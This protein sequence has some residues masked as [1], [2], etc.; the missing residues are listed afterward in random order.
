MTQNEVREPLTYSGFSIYAGEKP[1]SKETWTAG[2]IDQGG[3]QVGIRYGV[4]SG[5]AGFPK[6]TPDLAPEVRRIGQ[7]LSAYD[8]LGLGIIDFLSDEQPADLRRVVAATPDAG[9]PS[10]ELIK[11]AM[12]AVGALLKVDLISFDNELRL[13]LTAL[14]EQIIEHAR[15][16]FDEESDRESLFAE[17]RRVIESDDEV[18]SYD[19]YLAELAAD[20]ITVLP[21]E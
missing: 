6:K 19:D 8:A 9:K 17:A 12:I 3:D 21:G 11:Q 20:G 10:Q 18:T 2:G 15:R 14:G 1:I 13:H 16:R 7:A 5:R 4:A